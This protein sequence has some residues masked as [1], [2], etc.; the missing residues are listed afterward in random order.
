MF[1]ARAGEWT[2]MTL[3]QRKKGVGESQRAAQSWDQAGVPPLRG[4]TRSQEVNAGE[5]VEPLR[6]G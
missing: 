4:S 5:K 3:P 6:S 1:A 2:A